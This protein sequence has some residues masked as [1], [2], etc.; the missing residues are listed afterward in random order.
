MPSSPHCLGPKFCSYISVYFKAYPIH[1]PFG[2]SQAGLWLF[3][4]T[5][6]S[7]R[8]LGFYRGPDL[9]T[10]PPGW[11]KVSSQGFTTSALGANQQMWEG[12]WFTQLQLT[13][14]VRHQIM[15]QVQ[16]DTHILPTCLTR[17]SFA[18]LLCPVHSSGCE[19]C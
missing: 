8:Q 18:G 14:A 13:T 11:V 16:P 5:T 7:G 2:S 6:C 1:G 4:E 10:A 19:S 9:T 3:L 17:V 12:L 15:V